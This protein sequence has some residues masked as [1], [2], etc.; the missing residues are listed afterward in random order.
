MMPCPHCNML[1]STEAMMCPYCGLGNPSS[2]V[3]FDQYWDDTKR[4]HICLLCLTIV[5]LSCARLWGTGFWTM[6]FFALS[7]GFLVLN[8]LYLLFKQ[9]RF[10]LLWFPFLAGLYVFFKLAAQSWSFP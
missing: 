1:V 2:H 9:P 10:Y 3:A 7:S 5:A 6:T 4:A 8:W